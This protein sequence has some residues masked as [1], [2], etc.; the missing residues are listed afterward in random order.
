MTGMLAGV[1]AV[2]CDVVAHHG[3]VGPPAGEVGAAGG[4]DGPLL[5]A[6]GGGG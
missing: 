6:G 2:L 4:A 1:A 5:L 3:P